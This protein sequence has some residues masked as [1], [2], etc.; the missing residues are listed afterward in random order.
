MLIKDISFPNALE[1]VA[2]DQIL[3]ESAEADFSGEVLRFWEPETFFIV[4]GRISKLEE[5][6]NTKEARKDNIEILRR[7]SAGGTVLQGPGCLNYSLILSYERDPL[8]KN[9]RKSYGYIL[10]NICD[11]LGGSGVKAT[12]EPLS[13]IAFNGKKF[14]GNA[15]ARRKKYLLHHGTILYDFPIERIEKYIKMPKKEPPYRMGR[16]HR[17]FLTNI[18]AKPDDIKQAI[19]SVFEKDIWVE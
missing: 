1:N 19:S 12:F 6:V 11:S 4:L 2:Y 16:G 18:K 13:D 7:I 17:D 10:N 8:L 14:S 5:S 9:I 15:Q 3:L